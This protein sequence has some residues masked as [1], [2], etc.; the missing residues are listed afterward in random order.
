MGKNYGLRGLLGMSFLV[1]LMPLSVYA[2]DMLV[3]KDA[4]GVNTKFVVTDTGTVGIGT[5]KP[6]A[7]LQIGTVT[8]PNIGTPWDFYSYS[9]SYGR[10]GIDSGVNNAGIEFLE[11]SVR[12]WFMGSYNGT[13]GVYNTPAGTFA[14]AITPS[15]N[16]G[17]GTTTPD[18]PLQMASG[19][20]VST[21]GVWTNASSREY[22]EN[23]GELSASEATD[24]LLKLD[25]VKYNYKV[26]KE[27]RHVGFIA[28]DVPDLVAT[29]DRKGL[30]PMDIVAVLTK[31]VQEQ[32]KTI[33]GLKE[34]MAELKRTASSDQLS[35][36][37]YQRSVASAKI[38][39]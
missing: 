38:V 27:D 29:K 3:V 21:G 37:S 15:G 2:T 26:D 7:A 34:E 31:V 9:P 10:V 4:G 23:I 25:P 24:A 6:Q 19:A 1:L 16:V 33:A 20:Y 11:S 12:K 32:Q 5:A 35:A 8:L 14:L 18:Y 28:E 17:I 39:E 36:I 22:K 30:S 13:F